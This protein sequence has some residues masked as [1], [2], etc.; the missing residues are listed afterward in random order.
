LLSP[1][2]EGEGGAIPAFGLRAEALI[3]SYPGRWSLTINIG[4][5]VML[6]REYSTFLS[7]GRLAGLSH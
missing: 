4:L 6:G 1:A 3:V 7:A 2:G 5:V